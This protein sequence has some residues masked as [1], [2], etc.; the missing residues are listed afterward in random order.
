MR[1]LKI[2]SVFHIPNSLKLT[3]VTP[4]FIQQLSLR[5]LYALT[6]PFGVLSY[7]ITLK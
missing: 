7:C 5:I 6:N 2:H 1:F 3:H 4:A